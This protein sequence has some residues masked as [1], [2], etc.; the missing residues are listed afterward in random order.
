MLRKKKIKNAKVN[1]QNQ[2]KDTKP[3]KPQVA[4]ELVRGHLKNST[5]LLEK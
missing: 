5:C 1:K 3:T 2:S 4:T